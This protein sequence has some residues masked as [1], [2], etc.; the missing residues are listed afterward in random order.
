MHG[1]PNNLTADETM[2]MA[3]KHARREK[4]VDKWMHL[5]DLHDAS[6]VIRHMV[7]IIEELQGKV[8]ELE[9]VNQ[10]NDESNALV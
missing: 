7:M 8:D 3:K 2:A 6:T 10:L 4:Q 9:A 5:L 1:I